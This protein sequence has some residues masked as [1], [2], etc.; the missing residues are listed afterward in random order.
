MKK[1]PQKEDVRNMRDDSS[2]EEHLLRNEGVEQVHCSAHISRAIRVADIHV[3]YVLY[4]IQGWMGG[5]V[6]EGNVQAF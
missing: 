1:Y 6:L 5:D 3:V 4:I 2:G